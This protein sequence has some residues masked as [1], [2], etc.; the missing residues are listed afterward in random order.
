MKKNRRGWVLGSMPGERP[1][2]PAWEV[3]VMEVLS[4]EDSSLR[5]AQTR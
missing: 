2:G 5:G 3:E 4:T 1:R